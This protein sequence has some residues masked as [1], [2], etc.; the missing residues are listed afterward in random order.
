MG[1]KLNVM[2][3][4]TQLQAVISFCVNLNVVEMHTEEEID[5]SQIYWHTLDWT[6][7]HLGLRVMDKSK[8]IDFNVIPYSLLWGKNE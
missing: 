3:S 6:C 1:A 8:E 7:L 4:K 5:Q 2:L